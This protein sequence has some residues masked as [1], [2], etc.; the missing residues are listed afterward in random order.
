MYIMSSLVV[1]YSHET[2][3]YAIIVQSDSRTDVASLPPS[4]PIFNTTLLRQR[5][6]TVCYTIFYFY[7]TIF[8]A[9]LSC[10]MA[11]RAIFLTQY[12]VA[13]TCCR[14]LKAIQKLT[15]ILPNF[16]GVGSCNTLV[17]DF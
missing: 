17:A 16:V 5:S 6:A 7:D 3:I 1:Q 10:N 4:E 12:F 13:A 8:Y 11:H 2:R 14:F 15:T 9:T